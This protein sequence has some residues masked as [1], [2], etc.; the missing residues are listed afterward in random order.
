TGVHVHGRVVAVVAPDID[1]AVP[2]DQEVVRDVAEPPAVLVVRL[3]PANDVVG[4][5]RRVIVR[6]GRVVDVGHLDVRLVAETV[7]ARLHR[8]PLRAG[9]HGWLL[10]PAGGRRGRGVGGAGAR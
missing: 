5:R 7:L 3:D 1:R 10:G 4:L 6:A 9:H 8:T 2:V